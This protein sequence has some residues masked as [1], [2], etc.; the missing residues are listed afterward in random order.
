MAE[1]KDKKWIQ[2]AN[3]KKGALTKKAKAAGQLTKEGDIKDQW[4]EKVAANK[5]GQ[6]SK[7]TQQQARLALTFRRMRKRK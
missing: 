7:K 6:Y 3:I 1:K 2:K 4:I 5:S